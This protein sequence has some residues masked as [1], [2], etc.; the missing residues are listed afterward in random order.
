VQDGGILLVTA[1]DMAVLAG[2]N[3]AESCFAK[4]GAM[5]MKT[6][7]CQEMVFSRLKI[8]WINMNGNLNFYFFL[9]ALRIIIHAV[10]SSANRYGRCVIPLLSLKIDFYIRLMFKVIRSAEKAKE[11][12]L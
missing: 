4:Y 3:A 12:A 7:A 1:T 2:G 9:Q 6:K 11:S 10:Q 5:S 8:N